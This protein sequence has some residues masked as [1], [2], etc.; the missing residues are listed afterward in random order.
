MAL[1][2]KMEQLGLPHNIEQVLLEITGKFSY[3]L[4]K[5]IKEEFTNNLKLQEMAGDV[6][7]QPMAS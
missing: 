2:R 6:W 4:I 3:R 5:K 1:V 7:R